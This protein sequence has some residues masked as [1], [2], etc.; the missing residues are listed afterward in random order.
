[1][2]RYLIEKKVFAGLMALSIAI[3]P[4]AAAAQTNVNLPKNKYKVQD[5]VRLGREAAAQVDR[6]F[7]VMNDQ[8]AE[9][10]VTRVGERL[11]A[12]IPEQFQQPAFDYRFKVVNASDINAFALPGGP[13]YVNRGMIEAARNEGEMAG[14]M[15]HEISH[16]AL[17]HATA[18]QTKLNSPLN[19]ILGIG[20]V[21]GGAVVG[22]QAG[23]Q[24]GQIF[25]AGY[26]LRYSR[27]YETQADTLGAQI[28]ARAGYDPRD[29]ANMFQTIQQRSGGGGNPEWLSS[30]PDPGNR[31]Q[32]INREASLL[33]V[34]PSP[35]K[36]TRDFTRTQ[37]RLR[38]M[39]RAPSMAEI[40]RGGYGDNRGQSPR[41]QSPTSSGR[42]SSSVPY[43]STRVRS[44]SSGNWIS[45]NVPNNWREFSEQSGVTFAPE[46]AYGDQGITHGAIVGISRSGT[47]NLDDATEAYV[48]QLLSGNSYLRQRGSYIRTS[49]GGRQGYTTQLYGRSPITGQNEIVT[50]YTTMLR[51][52]DL[53]NIAA[54]APES[55]SPAY[56]S[57]FR[58]LISS[59]RLND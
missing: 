38:G 4:L 25:A 52:G 8:Q 53:V 31:F 13:M 20:A 30:H 37:E 50:I 51:N 42:Y 11:V 49:V 15:A 33:N 29:L 26:F 22:G 16:V 55:D 14:V 10:Y 23:A 46:G 54:V 12:A 48:S 59:I 27:E 58:S 45:L 24:A 56:S 5:D 32:K 43:P 39:S 44:Y 3:L 34:S 41:S 19:Q 17:R 40:E 47:N 36:G 9:D 21:L 6:Q 2:K 18:Q 57:A 7:P 1:M 28:M 35:I